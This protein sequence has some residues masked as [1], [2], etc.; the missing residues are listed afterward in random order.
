MWRLLALLMGGLL[1]LEYKAPLSQGGHQIAQAAVVLLG[2]GLTVC[3][4]RYNR[5]ALVH[6]AYKRELGAVEH[7]PMS[8]TGRCNAL[9]RHM[10]SGP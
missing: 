4:L 10:F 9:S 6:E 5:G 2:Y 1:V 3:W 7:P 8:D